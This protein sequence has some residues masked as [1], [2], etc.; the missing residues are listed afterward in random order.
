VVKV[1][2][3]PVDEV[4]ALSLNPGEDY[5][6]SAVAVGNYAYFG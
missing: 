5:L 1:L 4:G 3:R 6:K 2:L